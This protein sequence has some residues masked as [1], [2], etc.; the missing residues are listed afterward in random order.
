M[1]VKRKL[2]NHVIL[3]SRIIAEWLLRFR[4]PIVFGCCLS[5]VA[6]LEVAHETVI[7]VSYDVSVLSDYARVAHWMTAPHSHDVFHDAE[8]FLFT[9]KPD[10]ILTLN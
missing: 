10:L 2:A 8:S 4:D 5:Q 9:N 6:L 1:N 3:P 7:L